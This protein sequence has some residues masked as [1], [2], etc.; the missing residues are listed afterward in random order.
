[1]SVSYQL[2]P[3]YV[4]VYGGGQINVGN[5]GYVFDVGA[6]LTAGGG[7]IVAADADLANALDRYAPLFRSSETSDPLVPVMQDRLRNLSVG[8]AAAAGEAVFESRLNNEA[9]PRFRLLANGT[10][11][12][13][14][15][16]VAP[17]SR[18]GGTF[19]VETF[20][21]RSDAVSDD[22][23]AVQAAI[24]AA[25]AAGGGVVQLP[26]GTT[27]CTSG[28][29]MRSYVTLRGQGQFATV[30]KITG[31]ANGALIYG[32]DATHPRFERL[33]ITGPGIAA[34]AAGGIRL[35]HS[36]LGNVPHF[37][38]EH[39]RIT[40]I[41]GDAVYIQDAILGLLSDCRIVNAAGHG[42][43]IAIGTSLTFQSCYVGAAAQGGYHLDTATYCAL[44][45]CASENNG[46]N[47]DLV[48]S[49]NID[50]L[51]CGAE[52][53]K[54]TSAAY[55]G[56]HYKQAGG[57][58]VTYLGCYARDFNA[59]QTDPNYFI[60][61]TSGQ[62]TFIGFRGVGTPNG[63]VTSRYLIATG[64]DVVFRGVSFSGTGTAGTGTLRV[65][66]TYGSTTTLALSRADTSSF[67]GLTLRTG[68]VDEWSWQ[69]RND[70][71]Q[72]LYLR[73]NA[74]GVT[75]LRAKQQASSG[76]LAVGAVGAPTSTLDVQGSIAFKRTSAADADY[77]VLATDNIIG[78]PTLT[79][80]R[81]V[82]LPTAAS[83]AGRMYTVKDE[84]G[85]AAAG[86]TLTLTPQAGQFIDGAATKV[87]N[88][89]YGFLRVYSNGTN[90]H[91]I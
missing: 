44:I 68:S 56:T 69:M 75:A 91:T 52:T 14:P 40:D 85:S 46:I 81:V 2:R 9:Y 86:R 45:A 67:G 17:T 62:A 53:S 6:A 25:N 77:T 13:G 63:P 15:G 51:A 50:L 49:S 12:T 84:S 32:S 73:D 36:V 54:D 71:T 60:H 66:E 34:S 1:V 41:P 39:V 55:P 24:D 42:F 65:E 29:T 47:Y 58:Q 7:T 18:A 27:L 43:N 22:T 26:A 38:F 35:L 70:G 8:N 90:W 76:L 74:N 83:V 3:Q 20:G 31:A 28:L 23:A 89:A 19:A 37:A 5:A 82:T 61:V 11:M 33:T 87:I 59:G 4:G 48:A 16:S 64:A 78:F 30:L 79:A 88:T 80:S 57:T 10:V 21:A 72:D